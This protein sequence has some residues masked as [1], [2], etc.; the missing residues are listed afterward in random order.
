MKTRQVNLIIAAAA[1]LLT[2]TAVKADTTAY[3]EYYYGG[4]VVDIDRVVNGYLWIEDATVNLYKNAHIKTALYVGDV[5]STSGAVLNIYGGRIDDALYIT[6]NYNGLPEATVTVYGY[7][8]AVAGVPVA[9]RTPELFIQNK[10]LSGFYADGTPFAYK[11]DCF[12]EGTFKLT[13]KLGWILSEPEMAVAPEAIDFG[14]VK[15]TESVT[16]T[17]SVANTGTANLILQSIGFAEGSSAEF[18]CASVPQLPTTIEPG[19]SIPVEVVF[20]PAAT[21]AALAVMMIRGDTVDAAQIMLTGSGIKPVIAVEAAALDFGQLDLGQS[22]VGTVRVANA[23]DADLVVQ[24]MDFAGAGSAEFA[25]VAAPVLPVVI[26]AGASV[27]LEIAYT[28][29]V[30]GDAEAVLMIVSDDVD[31]PTVEVELKGKAVDPVQTPLEQ[32]D[33]IL[34]FYD[35]GIKDKTIKGVGHNHRAVQAQAHVVR[36]MLVCTRCLIKGGYG[37]W[38]MWG[39]YDIEK[40]TDGKGHPRDILEGSAVP[41]LNAKIDVLIDTLK[42]K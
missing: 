7:G 32:M 9:E 31:N 6:T 10:V 11:V 29:T 24:S 17:V 27:A 40:K 13:L 8:F 4:A 33:S 21:G 25:F 16:R 22:A 12:A 28:P 1:V 2:S 36:Q 14:A 42:K 18:A 5:F 20:T 15:I 19:A 39:L 34:K 37:K 38:A 26:A 30:E 35:Q 41:E 23:G 3:G